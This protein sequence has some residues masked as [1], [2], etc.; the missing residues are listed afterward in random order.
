M[1]ELYCSLIISSPCV[2]AAWSEAVEQQAF[3]RV[4]RLGQTREVLIERIVIE[5][6]VE[7][8]ILA[9]Q[10]KKK[11]QADAALGDRRREE[12]HSALGGLLRALQLLKRTYSTGL[13]VEELASCEI[14]M[15]VL[16]LC[17]TN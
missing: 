9:L 8:R 10:K 2:N 11:A 16:K 3:D 6:T 7:D 5:D 1:R 17:V 12:L 15:N 4:Y 13:N 14:P